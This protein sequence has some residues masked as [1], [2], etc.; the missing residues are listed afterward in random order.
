MSDIRQFTAVTEALNQDIVL[1]V[2]EFGNI[3]HSSCEENSGCPNKNL[4]DAFLCVWVEGRS[5][6]GNPC[7]AALSCYRQCIQ[8]IRDSNNLTTLIARR[9][10]KHRF[11]DNEQPYGK[12]TPSMGF[13]LHFGSSIEGLIGTSL[14][15]DASYLGGDVDLADKLEESTKIYDT[16]ILM[17]EA[18]YNRLSEPV[19][20]TCRLV[21]RVSHTLAPEPF[22]LYA[23]NVAS[24]EGNFFDRDLQEEVFVLDAEASGEGSL[25]SNK[26]SSNADAML[27]ADG[28]GDGDAPSQDDDQVET[29]GMS[30]EQLAACVDTT[31]WTDQFESGVESYIK[32]DWGPALNIL[33]E[34]LES[35]PYDGPAKKLVAY[36]NQQD[37]RAPKSWT[38]CAEL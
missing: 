6:K 5:G 24:Q 2:N 35:K 9:E 20:K 4:G 28:D 38:G 7:D 10:I 29:T 22:K 3:C 36:M 16:P 13:G 8:K 21:D 18:F 12:Y 34:C 33:N 27:D 17:T 1:F 19:Q 26:K 15:M 32:G 14:K 23:A 30:L 11:P 31:D 25:L 37:G